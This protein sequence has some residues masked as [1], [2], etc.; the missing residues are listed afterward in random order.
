MS[1]KVGPI[2]I[3]QWGQF[4][5]ALNKH[6][7]SKDWDKVVMINEVMI[8]ALQREG[9]AK[10]R[11]QFTARQ[12]LAKTHAAILAQLKKEKDKLEV[13]MKQFQSQQDGIAAYQLTSLS[14]DRD[15][16]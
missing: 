9:K 7:K 1:E 14:G 6:S 13:E 12:A 10:T 16:I 15:D 5:T 8:K 11:P 4:E 3:E 2:S